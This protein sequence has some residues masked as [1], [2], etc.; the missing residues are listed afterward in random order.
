MLKLIVTGA[1]AAALPAAILPLPKHS[2]PN[3]KPLTACQLVTAAEVA[4]L[5]KVPAVHIDS[6]SSGK[7]EMLN[8]DLC[9]WY[10]R[11]GESE[12]VML[13]LRRAPSSDKVPV[14]FIAAKIEPEFSEPAKPVSITGVGQEAVYV[15]Y[16]DGQGGTIVFRQRLAV[17]TITGSPA[18]ETLVGMA[19]AIVPRL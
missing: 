16:R 17:V 8:V 14:A 11:E 19:K 9:S 5:L 15:A 12:G 3:V 7:N 18:K 10:V 13:K 2:A 4:G 6:I 1:L